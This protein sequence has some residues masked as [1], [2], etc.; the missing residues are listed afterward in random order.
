MK[1][2]NRTSAISWP[3]EKKS[4]GK[5]NKNIN[6]LKTDLSKLEQVIGESTGERRRERDI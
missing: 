4:Q 6:K 5:T 3:K 1:D 2:N